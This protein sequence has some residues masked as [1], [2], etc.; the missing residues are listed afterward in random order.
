MRDRTERLA[1]RRQVTTDPK[2][3]PEQKVNTSSTLKDHRL[4]PEIL[5]RF[6]ETFDT[7]FL[8][9]RPCSMSIDCT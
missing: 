2:D 6:L 4:P 9:V 5:K 1:S 3:K 8:G 7:L